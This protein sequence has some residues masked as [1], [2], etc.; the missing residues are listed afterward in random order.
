MTPCIQCKYELASDFRFCPRCGVPAS[1][2]IPDQY[3]LARKA[4][5][6]RMEG[7]PVGPAIATLLKAY[8]M[9]LRDAHVLCGLGILYYRLGD[10]RR[11]PSTLKK[12]S[13][14]SRISRGTLR[15]GPDLLSWRDRSTRPL[16]R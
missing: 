6:G 16:R 2:D 5:E 1:K 15:P 4:M 13:R 3:L 14:S 11:R 7:G 8:S 10:I 9:G 12:P